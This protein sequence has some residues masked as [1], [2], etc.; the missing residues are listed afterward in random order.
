[1]EGEGSVQYEVVL[2]MLLLICIQ[3]NCITHQ[4]HDMV[5]VV[6]SCVTIFE[7]T[8]EIFSIELSRSIVKTTSHSHRLL[9]YDIYPMR[10]LLSTCRKA[11]GPYTGYT[12]QASAPTA[13]WSLA[14]LAPAPLTSQRYP[15]R[16]QWYPYL[17]LQPRQN[18]QLANLSHLQYYKLIWISQKWKI[19]IIYMYL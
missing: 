13:H 18:C 7:T 16:D 8:L 1:M 12:R 11:A 2:A 15:G 4:E 6:S 3:I 5:R 10:T 17:G 19:P 9:I 14:Y